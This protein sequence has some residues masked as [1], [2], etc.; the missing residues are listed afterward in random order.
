MFLLLHFAC[1]FI[2]GYTGAC[3]C[4]ALPW[5]LQGQTDS[6]VANG[7][8]NYWSGDFDPEQPDGSQMSGCN[9]PSCGRPLSC[10]SRVF[11]HI[12]GFITLQVFPQLREE[13]L[14]F[15]SEEAVMG[16]YASVS[17]R[18]LFPSSGWEITSE[19]SLLFSQITL[20]C[21]MGSARSCRN[22]R[23]IV[24]QAAGECLPSD[25]PV[26]GDIRGCL[27]EATEQKKALNV[28]SQML[29]MS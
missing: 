5:E 10:T 13:T 4:Q 18:V 22:K 6:S 3:A 15:H 9:L 27:S 21:L 19:L 25:V 20:R 1:C 16:L 12:V 29:V 28:Q 14:S 26:D 17:L 24:S 2:L 11:L 23:W 7:W 8:M